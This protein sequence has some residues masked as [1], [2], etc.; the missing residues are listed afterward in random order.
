MT[1]STMVMEVRGCSTPSTTASHVFLIS[2]SRLFS[3][4]PGETRVGRGQVLLF[5]HMPHPGLWEEPAVS[6]WVGAGP[7]M[8]DTGF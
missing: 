2:R 7:R 8:D 5:L 1:C 4:T 3:A 6:A